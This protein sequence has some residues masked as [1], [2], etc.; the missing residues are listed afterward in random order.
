[1]LITNMHEFREAT[2]QT[3]ERREEKKRIN[4][5]YVYIYCTIFNEIKGN[6]MWT[7]QHHS[8]HIFELVLI[9]SIIVP[10]CLF[11]TTFRAGIMCT[12][13]LWMRRLKRNILSIKRSNTSDD[14]FVVRR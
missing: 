5:V 6:E 4:A 1:M 10:F 3:N 2:I 9:P 12:H 8:L 14:P 13:N 11:Y 7:P